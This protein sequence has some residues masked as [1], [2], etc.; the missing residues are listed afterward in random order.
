MRLRFGARYHSAACHRACLP[1]C[2]RRL[3]VRLELGARSTAV[4]ISARGKACFLG[5]WEVLGRRVARSAPRLPAASTL[6]VGFGLFAQIDQLII[7]LDGLRPDAVCSIRGRAWTRERPAP[8]A[9]RA[10]GRPVVGGPWL[11][12]AAPF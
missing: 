8:L 10:R 7:G 6:G 12:L 2:L 5:V 1:W 9:C 3:R 4:R 11:K